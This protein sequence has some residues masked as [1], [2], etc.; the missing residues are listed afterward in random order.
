MSDSNQD[1]KIN[2]EI[3]DA[4][5]IVEVENDDNSDKKPT[6][7]YRTQQNG[8]LEILV[9]LYSARPY[10]PEFPVLFRQRKQDFIFYF[11]IL[12]KCTLQPAA[13]MENRA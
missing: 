10:K 4:G 13:C 1:K 8:R 2:M 12:Y 9:T 6:F 11:I 7:K 3:D 5:D